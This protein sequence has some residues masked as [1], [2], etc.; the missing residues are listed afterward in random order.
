[1]PPSVNLTTIITKRMRDEIT[2]RVPSNQIPSSGWE[3]RTLGQYFLGIEGT[4]EQV[5]R[6]T[7][8]SVLLLLGHSITQKTWAEIRKHVALDTTP[9][10]AIDF[11]EALIVEDYL[12]PR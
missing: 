5:V 1:M 12:A 8:E 11:V 4:C 9:E 6:T 2:R 7:T 10:R 3:K